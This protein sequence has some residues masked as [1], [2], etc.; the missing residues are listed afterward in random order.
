[1]TMKKDKTTMNH[2]PLMRIT[3]A[4]IASLM[5]VCPFSMGGNLPTGANVTHGNVGISTN[6]RNMQIDQ[7]S[8]QAIVN[9]ESFGIGAGHAVN[10]SQPDASAAMLSRVIGSD[11]S[12][13]FGSLTANGSFYLVNPNGVYFGPDSSVDVH[14]LIASTLDISDADFLAGKL[15][16]SGDSDGVITNDGAL[17]AMATI[18]LLARE[19]RNNGSIAAA[20]VGIAAG[21][22]V[23][24][25]LVA[26]GK[27]KLKLDRLAGN[28]GVAELN[29]DSVINSAGGEIVILSDNDTF[30]RDGASV[31]AGSGFVEISGT[32]YVLIAGDLTAGEIFIDPADLDVDTDVIAP[33]NITLQASGNI[34]INAGVTVQSTGGSVSVSADDNTVVGNTPG[35]GDVT[36]GAGAIIDAFTDL[37]ISGVG[38][39][40]TDATITVGDNL[41]IVATGDVAIPGISANSFD[42]S[43]VG[44]TATGNLVASAGTGSIVGTGAVNIAAANASGDLIIDGVGVTATGNLSGT[45]AT[46]NGSTG[47]TTVVGVSGESVSLD[48]AIVTATGILSAAQ[49]NMYVSAGTSA[50][51]VE[52]SASNGTVTVESPGH[53]SLVSATADDILTLE[54]GSV[55][56]TGSISSLNDVLVDADIGD[57]NVADVTGSSVGL[58]SSGGAVTASGLVKSTGAGDVAIQADTHIM[59]SDVTAENGSVFLVADNTLSFGALSAIG[60]VFI[61]N[62]IVTGSGHISAGD[63]VKIHTTQDVD[64]TSASGNSVEIDGGIVTATG[65]L[66]A[67]SGSI[68][69]EAGTGPASTAAL[70][71]DTEITV[72]GFGITATGDI[73]AGDSVVLTDH[74]SDIS[75]QSVSGSSLDLTGA[76]I[77]SSDL[78]ATN[79]SIIIAGDSASFANASAT[80]GSVVV[81]GTGDVLSF[82]SITATGDVNLSGWGV[83]ERSQNNRSVGGVQGADI[84]IQGNRKDVLLSFVQGS[85]VTISGKAVSATDVTATTTNGDI[86]VTATEAASFSSLNASS[87]LVDINAVGITVTGATSAAGTVI[88]NGNTGAV[89]VQNV[90]ANGAGSPS[91]QISGDSIQ[92]NGDLLTQSGGQDISLQAV[93]NITGMNHGIDAL[94]D[95]SIDSTSGGINLGADSLIEI[96]G[97]LAVTAETGITLGDI[98]GQDLN[99][100]D[101]LTS[102]VSIANSQ[103]DD[104]TGIQGLVVTVDYILG[105]GG[106]DLDAGDSITTGDVDFSG[107]FTADAPTLIELGR[108]SQS[109][110]TS[111]IRVGQSTAPD[112]Y[113]GEF[114]DTNGEILITAG[115]VDI[116][117]GSV[118]ANTDGSGA[119][120]LTI[121]ATKT[122]GQPLTIFEATSE[123]GPLTLEGGSIDIAGSGFGGVDAGTGAVVINGNSGTVDSDSPITGATVDIDG[124]A[125]TATDTIQSTNGAITVDGDSTDLADLDSDSGGTMI[126]TTGALGV[127][128]INSEMRISLIGGSI[129]ASSSLIAT[130]DITLNSSGLVDIDGSIDGGIVDIIATGNIDLADVT[131]ASKDG[132]SD[133]INLLGADIH[134]TGTLT[135]DTG[136]VDIDGDSAAIDTGIDAQG[137]I[138][139]S[140]TGDISSFILQSRFG[141]VMLDSSAGNI[142]IANGGRID[143]LQDVTIT[144]PGSVNINGD[145]GQT[146]PIDNLTVSNPGVFT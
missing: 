70:T 74:G 122:A 20:N 133:G 2:S 127:N 50:N 9:W 119:D 92:L 85:D 67:N 143:A 53:I 54:G 128:S 88:L 37:S 39:T 61:D 112:E 142:S 75:A 124:A 138:D 17:S 100:G 8:G 116:S 46:I 31:D 118:S 94:G 15:A 33:G 117:S 43:G 21:Q 77:S 47:D 73:S 144:S 38:V 135:A 55:T 114:M 101:N 63:V 7:I 34:N 76:T 79:G 28:S 123:G 125:I 105:P 24:I 139:I 72:I 71:A 146:A 130:G 26:G 35:T 42:I 84:I 131:A 140:A 86:E 78:T 81:T 12:A 137:H 45:D 4:F 5:A 10:V 1:M 41:S 44:I 32:N 120:A 80:N 58:G 110:P 3:S 115:S 52:L 29:A 30:F 90:T 107:N 104:F 11:P 25:D 129:S 108:V 60:D 36:A 106:V 48:G 16:F 93:N 6:G 40:L 91:L 22:S 69:I 49:G 87:G 109:F 89:A 136:N 97:I 62:G 66:T 96:D 59:V 68:D 14:S 126:T 132:D 83:T 82:D 65:T 18:A 99:V 102:D 95:V 23:L 19:V 98:E 111:N 56:A 134:A 121:R 57:I 113:I 141:S 51:L 103:A 13:I 27:I 145:I 64:I